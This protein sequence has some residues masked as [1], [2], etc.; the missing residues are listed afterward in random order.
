MIE[1]KKK[2]ECVYFIG[3]IKYNFI[4]I[5]TSNDPNK[6]LKELQTG[7]PFQLELIH[8][9][10]N[11][12]EK[13]LHEKFKEEKMNGEWF[14]YLWK[15]HNLIEKE[16][17]KD[18]SLDVDIYPV[19]K[20]H[21]DDFSDLTIEDIKKEIKNMNKDIKENYNIDSIYIDFEQKFIDIYDSDPMS[22]RDKENKI[23]II[24]NP[25]KISYRIDFNDK[26]INFINFSIKNI[27]NKYRDPIDS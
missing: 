8:T 27:H 13:E 20:K 25:Y 17:K 15:I 9:T 23:N 24:H 7:C 11:Y 18:K 4:K 12:S 14:H 1:E 21:S 19:E 16:R 2:E 10:K 3:N 6:R 5:G 26:Y 22:Q